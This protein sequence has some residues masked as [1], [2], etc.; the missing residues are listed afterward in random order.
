MADPSLVLALDTSGR[1]SVGLARAA[2]ILGRESLADPRAHVEQLMPLIQ[3]CLQGAGASLD[4]VDTLVVG[5]GPGPFTGLRVGIATAQILAEVRG[6][7]LR[8]VCSL[9]VIARAYAQERRRTDEPDPEVGP[10]GFVVTSDARRREVYWARYDTGGRRLQGPSV[11]RPE[12]VPRLPAVGP[13]VEVYPDRLSATPGPR[14]LDPG[15]LAAIGSDLPDAG[16]T[17]LYLR[18]PDA[19][20]PGRRKSVLRRGGGR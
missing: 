12:E 2:D 13:G 17:P 1:V 15:L 16:L 10:N 3:T 6:L 8:G 20:E 5:V 18:R 9:D 14:Q 4:A 19:A 7:S 11:G